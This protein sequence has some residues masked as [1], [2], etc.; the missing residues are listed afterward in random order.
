MKPTVSFPPPPS[1]GQAVAGTQLRCCARSPLAR[2]R[3]PLEPALDSD[4]GRG[5]HSGRFHFSDPAGKAKHCMRPDRRSR[6]E[7]FGSGKRPGSVG[8]IRQ[9][10]SRSWSIA[11]RVPRR[12]AAFGTANGWYY[13]PSTVHSP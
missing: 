10:A 11:Y 6:P 9:P 3:S 5:W 1:R 12:T 8:R 13:R 2:G 7:L 4:R